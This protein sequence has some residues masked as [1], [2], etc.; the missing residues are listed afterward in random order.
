MSGHGAILRL[1]GATGDH[2]IFTDICPCLGLCPTSR[3][4]QRPPC[5]QAVHQLAFES[6]TTLNVEGLVDGFVRDAHGFVIR[7]VDAQPVRHL[8]GR[9]T[10]APFSVTSMRFVAT[11]KRCLS[12][13][14]NLMATSIMNLAFQAVL[15]VVVQS[16]VCHQFRWLRPSGNQLCLP[17]RNR[18]PILEL[19]STSCSVACQLS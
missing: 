8:F 18:R 4:S 19:A 3:Y 15:D 6:A 1:C 11:L 17:L 16:R 5:A 14:G 9:P 2:H 12:R 13:T 7:E 10:I